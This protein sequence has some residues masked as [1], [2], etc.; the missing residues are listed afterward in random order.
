MQYISIIHNHIQPISQ[1]SKTNNNNKNE[2]TAE[3]TRRRSIPIIC[4]GSTLRVPIRTT[5]QNVYDGHFGVTHTLI[6]S[7]VCEG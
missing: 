4:S 7:H 1:N 3:K 5:S 6:R 2:N